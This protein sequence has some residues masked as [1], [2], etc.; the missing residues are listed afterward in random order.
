MQDRAALHR[1]GAH[2]LQE[3]GHD[4]HVVLRAAHGLVLR[5]G[6][7]RQDIDAARG[8]ARVRDRDPH[9]GVV[10]QPVLLEADS[11]AGPV[12]VQRP[13]ALARLHVEDEEVKHVL[14]AVHRLEGT[15]HE[16]HNV[17]NLVEH[18]QE[19]R[20]QG[21]LLEEV[22]G[23]VKRGQPLHIARVRIPEV[24]RQ[25][26]VP[27]ALHLL[28]H[29][30]G[31][32][33]PLAGAAALPPGAGNAEPHLPTDAVP[34]GAAQQGPRL[35]QSRRRARCGCNSNRQPRGCAPHFLPASSWPSAQPLGGEDKDAATLRVSGD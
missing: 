27:V 14:Q 32:G 8:R 16:V 5:V 34:R 19:L 28:A 9:R 22:D 10:G 20:R 4:T 21:R 31:V 25:G 33:R 35:R 2:V 6:V 17:P 15:A 1:Q 30:I 18:Q 11:A 12:A 29:P 3:V 7:R 13:S 24:P 23:A 26:G